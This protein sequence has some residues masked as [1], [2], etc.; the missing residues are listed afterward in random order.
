MTLA[1]SSLLPHIWVTC[2]VEVEPAIG[3]TL[4]LVR[5]G[6]IDTLCHASASGPDIWERGHRGKPKCPVCLEAAERL[7]I[8][9]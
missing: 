1:A 9:H 5:E 7:H 3:R 6:G 4:R 8:D 2:T